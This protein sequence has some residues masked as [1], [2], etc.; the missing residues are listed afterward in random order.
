MLQAVVLQEARGV[1]ADIDL[2]VVVALAV[3]PQQAQQLKTDS[4]VV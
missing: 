2:L 4:E 1:G 3:L